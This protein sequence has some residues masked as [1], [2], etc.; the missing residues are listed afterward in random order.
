[1]EI[2]FIN[3]NQDALNRANKVMMLLQ[4]Q[5]A[6]DELGLGRIR[7]AFSNFLFPGM[8]TLQTRA[9]YFLLLPALYAYLEKTKISDAGD[10]REKVRLNEISLTKRLD[11]G[12]TEDDRKG[13][14]GA[15]NLRKNGS[16]VKYDP[17]YVY[18]AGMETYGLIQTGGNLYRL[19]AECSNKFQNF[20]KKQKGNDEIEGDAEDLAG[21]RPVFLTCGEIYDFKGKDPMPISLSFK[22]ASFLRSQIVKTTPGSMINILL[23][24]DLFEKAKHCDFETLGEEVLEGHIPDKLYDIY[25]LARRYSR[26]AYLLRIR[27]AL[28]YDKAVGADEAK[29]K[30]EIFFNFLN[31]HKTEFAPQA[32]EE[33]VNFAS[34]VSDISCK[35]FCREAARLIYNNDWEALDKLLIDREIEIKTL[36]RSKLINAHEYEKGKPFAVAPPMSFRWNTIVRRVL[37]EISEGLKK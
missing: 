4:G 31:L 21:I 24:S 14:I 28:L 3:F 18:Q 1:M 26:F 9:K 37:T 10:A 34:G 6:I 30:E 11:K 22:E 12:T 23:D 33:I 27:Y 20:P 13:I 32:I 17:A 2:G 15:E 8:S 19:L 5:G 36:K 7:D 25:V 29:E 35:V 16:F